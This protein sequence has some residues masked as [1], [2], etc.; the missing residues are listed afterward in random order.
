MLKI[1][2][3]T[4]QKFVCPN[5]TNMP[6]QVEDVKFSISCIT[7][8]C[9]VILINIPLGNKRS[10]IH[11]VMTGEEVGDTWHTLNPYFDILFVE[12]QQT[13]AN[14]TMGHIC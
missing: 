5:K 6:V 2:H 12:I 11:L 3:P 10:K 14:I 8:L 13:C 4:Q 9:K 7:I 1:Y